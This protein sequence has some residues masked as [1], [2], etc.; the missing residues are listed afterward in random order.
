[1][2]GERGLS[3]EETVHL[4]PK[5]RVALM[6]DREAQRE[7]RREAAAKHEGLVKATLTK[8]TA[9]TVD[10]AVIYEE[11]EGRDLPLPEPAS[12]TATE[13]KVVTSF[14]PA[15]V[16]HEGRGRVMVV[17]PAAFTRPGGA[18]EDGAFGPEQILCAE[19][20]LYQV[21]RGIEESYHAANR[22]YRRGMLFSD[23]AVL[24]PDVVFM[25][26]GAV[27]KVDV[28]VVAE[29]QRVRAL[30]NHRSE[31]ECD[32]ALRDRV[33]TFLRIAAANDCETLVCGAFACGNLGYDP[34]QVI[35]LFRVWIAAHPGAIPRIVFAVPR[36]F[37]AAFEEAFEPEEEIVVSVPT[38]EEDD[39][40]WRTIDL[41]EGITLR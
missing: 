25:R 41:P 4:H 12:A 20:N 33:E 7:E 28:I 6:A 13:T 29:P 5:G 35:E 32:N 39:E 34:Q 21:L 19:S 24:L 40:D 8:E 36:A 9:G 26:G 14:A 18:Y 37:A 15:A 38:E 23:R 11:G 10:A 30:E 31:R 22:D 3:Y 2:E 1:M 27:K 17:D 16:F